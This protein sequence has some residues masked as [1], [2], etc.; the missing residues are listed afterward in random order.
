MVL[1]A[2]SE[3]KAQEASLVQGVDDGVRVAAMDREPTEEVVTGREP[4]GREMADEAVQNK[5]CSLDS[6]T[7]CS[8]KQLSK[9]YTILGTQQAMHLLHSIDPCHRERPC[10]Q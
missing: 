6:G 9:S 5:N 2:V 7:T 4:K 8:E 10:D 1:E 3:V